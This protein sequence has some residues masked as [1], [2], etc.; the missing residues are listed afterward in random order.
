M[1]D[2]VNVYEPEVSFNEN[3]WDI[4]G[5][6]VKGVLTVQPATITFTKKDG[7]ERVMRCTLHPDALPVQEVT[8]SK[9]P[10]KTSDSTLSVYDLEANGWRSFTIRAVKRVEFA[11]DNDE[12]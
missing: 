2:K 1:V 3:D 11:I 6:W 7:T 4:F 8:E 12:I 10:R 5:K 9:E